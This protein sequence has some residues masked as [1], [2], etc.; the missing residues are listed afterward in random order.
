V[1]TGAVIQIRPQAGRPGAETRRALSAGI[2]RLVL[3]ALLL[4]VVAG[5]NLQKTMLYYPDKALPSR[6]QMAADGIRFWPSDPPGYRGFIAAG[7]AGARGTVVVFHGN[8]G[9]AADRSYYVHVLAPLGYRVILAEYPSYGARSGGLGEGSF[10][11]DGRE[12][13]RLA[14]EQF[15]RP[16]FLLGE[17]LGSAV[18]AGIAKDSPV[19]GIILI[20]PWDTLLSVA[21]EKFPWLPVRLFLSD[22]YDSIANLRSF[23]AR[24]AVVGAERD[25]VI[26]IEHA[27]VLYE[28]LPGEKRMWTISGAG[29]NDW[30]GRVDGPWWREVTDYVSKGGRP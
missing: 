28:S 19:D 6:E 3:S 5:C 15:G 13:V 8:A 9:N 29:H 27:R 23:P 17:S 26:P 30:I 12:T 22:T 18:A 25:E 2:D 1:K 4:A 21:K 11:R 7:N 20:T 10:V 14:A 24:I 16:L